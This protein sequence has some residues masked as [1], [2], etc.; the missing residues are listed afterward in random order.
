[1]M[2]TVL[3]DDAAGGQFP[4]S[5]VMVATDSDEIRTICTECT[6]PD[7]TLMVVKDSL[8]GERTIRIDL[9]TR[10]RLDKGCS[11]AG[12]G[13]WIGRLSWKLLGRNWTLCCAASCAAGQRA[14]WIHGGWRGCLRNA[15]DMFEIL[16]VHVDLPDSYGMVGAASCQKADIGTEEESRQIV[17]VRFKLATGKESGGVLVLVHTP[18]VDIALGEISRRAAGSEVCGITLLLPA[19]SREPSLATLTLAT[20]TSSAGMS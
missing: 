11:A 12:I 7:P 13:D 8:E 17:F 5:C 14:L 2:S 1:M 15:F 20:G 19:A 18:D 3:S 10:N 9:L 6:I 16:L 4:Q